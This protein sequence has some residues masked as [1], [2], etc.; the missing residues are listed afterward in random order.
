MLYATRYVAATF[1]SPRIDSA[2]TADAATPV[3]PL[4]TID[5]TPLRFFFTIAQ[6]FKRHAR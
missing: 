4:I 5:A 2:Y 6:S 3:S 1:W